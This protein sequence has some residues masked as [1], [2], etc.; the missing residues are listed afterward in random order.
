MAVARP[1]GSP[2]EGRRFSGAA[3][4]KYGLIMAAVSGALAL[5][6]CAGPHMP[7]EKSTPAAMPDASLAPASVALTPSTAGTVDADTPTSAAPPSSAELKPTDRI[8]REMPDFSGVATTGAV[9]NRASLRN[10][11]VVVHFSPVDCWL[12]ECDVSP[13]I[14][15]TGAVVIAITGRWDGSRRPACAGA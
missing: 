1:P 11:V 14:V 7:A 12:A 10:K 4:A 15:S 8:G 9:V 2:H 3:I 13:K 5:A 6:G